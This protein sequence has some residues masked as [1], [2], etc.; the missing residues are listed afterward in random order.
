MTP[1]VSAAQLLDARTASGLAIILSLLAAPEAAC[2][3]DGSVQRWHPVGSPALSRGDQD[4][5]AGQTHGCF[6]L[7]IPQGLSGLTG[8]QRSS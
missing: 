8:Q 2:F 7:S 3:L 4:L 5:P 1:L 6:S